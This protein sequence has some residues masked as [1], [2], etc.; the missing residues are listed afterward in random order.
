MGLKPGE[1]YVN[2][3]AD[4]K[5]GKTYNARFGLGESNPALKGIALELGANNSVKLSIGDKADQRTGE[6]L[7]SEMQGVG[8]SPSEDGGGM[9][10]F[11]YR[12]PEKSP[13]AAIDALMATPAMEKF[14]EGRREA[15]AQQEAQRVKDIE[16]A[17]D[18]AYEQIK[19]DQASLATAKENLAALSEE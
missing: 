12:G 7:R 13:L 17:N 18:A 11:V 8:F 19:A 14:A 10:E 16:A 5:K 15:I 3:S 4:A 6:V 1:Y 9:N 2:D